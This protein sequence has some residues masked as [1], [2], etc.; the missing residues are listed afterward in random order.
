MWWKRKMVGVGDLGG[1]EVNAS[2][3]RDLNASS[4]PQAMFPCLHRPT[5]ENVVQNKGKF[6]YV[7]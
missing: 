5:Q 1:G 4:V 3:A 2:I 7:F 6:G